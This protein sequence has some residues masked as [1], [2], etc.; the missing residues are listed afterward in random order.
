VVAALASTAPAPTLGE[1]QPPWAEPDP[2]MIVDIA[3][4][5]ELSA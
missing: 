1:L 5:I 3:T 2:A 4:P